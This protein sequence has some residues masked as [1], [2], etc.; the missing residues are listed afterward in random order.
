MRSQCSASVASTVS[1]RTV[2]VSRCSMMSTAP[3]DPP[4]S[5]I[6]LATA[7]SAPGR[8]S[9]TTRSVSENCALGIEAMGRGP[10]LHGERA[11]WP[12]G[13]SYRR[14]FRG[15][16]GHSAELLGGALDSLR[17]RTDGLDMG[18]QL[19]DA[20]AIGVDDL[21]VVAEPERPLAPERTL[22]LE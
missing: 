14:V 11:R 6:A 7:A 1:S 21:K 12:V 18:D 2:A 9:S 17:R 15:L 22:A 3:I 13:Q 20:A 10:G 5:P 8:R 19:R 16:R 4:A